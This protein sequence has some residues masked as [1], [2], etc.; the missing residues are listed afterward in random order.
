LAAITL[1]KV[2]L[3]RKRVRGWTGFMM[4]SSAQGS[5]ASA[6]S[7]IQSAPRPSLR[8]SPRYR[9]VVVAGIGKTERMIFGYEGT[10]DVVDVVGA[11][12]VG[13]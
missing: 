6:W 7:F 9:F 1:K 13:E 11:L 3:E 8:G 5:V 2:K 10:V 12:A 4:H